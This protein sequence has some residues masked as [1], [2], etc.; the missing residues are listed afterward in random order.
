MPQVQEG[1]RYGDRDVPVWECAA[2]AGRREAPRCVPYGSVPQAQEAR[3]GAHIFQ[4]KKTCITYSDET[5]Y[6]IY[7]RKGTYLTKIP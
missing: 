5:L 1:L 4:A 3:R 7:T 2:G 6:Y